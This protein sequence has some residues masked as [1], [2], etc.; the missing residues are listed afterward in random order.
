VA[1]MKRGYR[2]FRL[3]TRTA[4]QL[5]RAVVRPLTIRC[6]SYLW[7]PLPEYRERGQFKIALTCVFSCAALLLCAATGLRAAEPPAVVNAVPATAPSGTSQ[8]VPSD[9]ISIP[10]ADL[11]GM[12]RAELRE[13]F[14][15]ADAP[16]L[17]AAHKLIERYFAAAKS[18]DRAAL[19][20]QID[21]LGLDPIALGRLVRLRMHWP[22]LAGGGVYYINQKRGPYDAKYFVG[23]PATYDRTRPWPLVV[24]LPTT[25]AFATKPPPN[26]DEVVKIYTAWIKDELSRHDDA[27][28]VMPLLDLKELYGPSYAGMNDALQP[29]IDVA[30]RVNIDPARVY[31]IGHS[32]AAH[33]TWNLGLHVP[34]Y[35]AAINPLAGGA[36]ADWQRIRLINLANVL[37]V[38]WTDDSDDVIKPEASKSLVRALRGLKQDVEFIETKNIGHAPTDAVVEECY[39]KVRARVRDL[40]PKSVSIQSNRPDS[41]FNRNDWVQIW[42]PVTPGDDRRL[43]FRHGTGYMVV[44]A[45][46]WRIDATGSANK[47]TVTTDN[48]EAFRLYVND[49]MVDLKKPVTVIVNKKA[50]FE[51]IVKC[52]TSEML[53]DQ[54]VMGR[55][56][57]YYCG[58]IDIDVVPPTTQPAT[59]PTTQSTTQPT[60]RPHK[61]RI[62]VGPAADQ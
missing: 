61:G 48:V 7:S 42:Q 60:T 49:Q 32:E 45:N 9:Q 35:F 59:R 34:T 33:A 3:A 28:V 20:A 52:S 29:V 27:V 6:R 50:K 31:L 57:R 18:T 39:A 53:K 11:I 40:Y 47:F 46:T 21:A 62:I 16:K 19:V 13:A 55:G 2:A 56:W 25:Q 51:G 36:S 4:R 30:D 14:L 41:V 37:P 5:C 38:V 44:D 1:A 22:A 26:A 24:K 43:Y 23:L 10:D 15:P 58:E 8:I 54:L 12:Y 17:L